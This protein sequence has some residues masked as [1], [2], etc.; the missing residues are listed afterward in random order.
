L[1]LSSEELVSQVCFHKCNVCRYAAYVR[2][3]GDKRFEKSYLDG[4]GMVTSVAVKDGKA[5][6]R[7]KFV[8]TEHFDKEEE[9]GVYTVGRCRLNLI[10]R[11]YSLSN[12]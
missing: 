12:P 6:F 10:T 7:N 1:N 2:G 11:T 5:Y 8:R 4:D 9:L 3:E